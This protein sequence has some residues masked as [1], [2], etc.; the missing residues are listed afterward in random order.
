MIFLL[1]ESCFF[2]TY[3]LIGDPN[4]EGNPETNQRIIDADFFYFDD[5]YSCSATA[6][7]S[8]VEKR[9]IH[10]AA[11][12]AGTPGKLKGYHSPIILSIR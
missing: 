6:D 2:L 1:I 8:G 3:F 7:F 4:P 12:A 9:A 10:L 11:A 5:L